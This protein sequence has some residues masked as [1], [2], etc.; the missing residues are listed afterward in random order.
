MPLTSNIG[1][2]IPNPVDKAAFDPGAVTLG[3][4][5]IT[6]TYTDAN[7]CTN[8]NTQEVLINPVTNVD[9]TI[10][11]AT[12]N[13][14]G[15]YELCSELGRVKLIG[16]PQANTGLPP[17]TMFTS[18]PAFPGGPLATILKDGSDFYIQTDGLVSN[19]Y[20]IRYD[21]KNVFGAV[22]FKMR[23][24]LILASPVA[25][26]TSSNNCIASDVLFTDATVINPTPFPTNLASWQWN[27]GDNSSSTMQNP[28]K[29]FSTSSTY[30]V[31]LKVTT[32]QGCSNTSAPLTHAIRVGDVP[33]P[34][35]QWAAIC[36]KDFTKFEDLSNPGN[37]SVITDYIW[38]FGD[39]N[40]L[41]GAAGASVPSG[42]HGGNTLGTYSLPDHKYNVFGT[43]DAKLTVTTNDGCSASI[44]KKVFILPY[45][46]VRPLENAAYYQTFEI[47]DGGWIAEAFDA[48]NSTRTN[49]IKSDTSWIWGIPTGQHITSGA[50]RS[51]KAWWT[52]RNKVGE[53]T[54]FANEN[55][56]VNGPCFDLTALK[57]PMISLDY[58]TD[59]DLSD[60]A[61]LQYSI[62]G[63]N[64]WRIVGPNEA[65]QDRDQGI[66]WFNGSS[67]PS[68]PGDQFLGQYGWTGNATNTTPRQGEWKNG[69]FNLDM[70]PM[71]NRSQVR[72]RVAFASNDGNPPQGP[73]DG[74]A[75]DN[76]FVGD[77]K[78]TVIVEHFTNSQLAASLKSAS[79]DLDDL[80]DDQFN[81]RVESDFFK[82]QYHM[83][84][85]GPDPLNT[86]NPTDPGARAFY[87]QNITQP[88]FTVM[89]GILGSYYNKVFIG[90][91][92][93]ITEI[94]ID[95]R[96]LED[97]AFVVDTIKIDPSA[98]SNIV[99]ATIE[100]VYVDSVTSL[101]SPV[102]F[103][104]ALIETDLNGN[105]NV[106]RKLLL[107][108]EGFTVNRAWQYM[109]KQTIDIN[110]TMDVQV[111]DP[112]KLYLVVFAQDFNT[113]RIHQAT[114]VKA[115]NKVG[116]PPVGIEDDPITA[117]IW[118]ISVFPN[119]AS[120]EVK[121]YLE[122]TLTHD[123]RWEI[124]DQRGVT[125]R[126]GE[127]NRDLSTPQEVAIHDL[128]N[129][130]YFVRF[131]L[132]DKTM[133]YRKLAIMN[134]H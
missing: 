123:F 54:Y 3:T 127:L 43:Y 50:R 36:N 84:V 68:N 99:R 9:F 27:F 79:Q 28:T 23:D 110:Y 122:N 5:Y 134:N 11:G 124:V 31:T 6:Y 12:L 94:E 120:K 49:I 82:I 90:S 119:P 65:L 39:G 117:E 74:F 25:E 62:D 1:S 98:P 104:A 2:T 55:S 24:V 7:N 15:Q 85:P 80:Y 47:T 34:D 64:N 102:T 51:T 133:V 93:N 59:A 111:S 10:Q 96:A 87:Y 97:P 19:T 92:K 77:K 76:V 108:S 46:T 105:K 114:M 44:T 91:H 107:Q 86:Q 128:A 101:R 89:D 126:D 70:I 100:F 13:A 66:N 22:T 20:R 130:I 38:D 21:F 71:A 30:Y 83:G 26:F 57:R 118:N 37:I 58:F 61:V 131:R 112:S 53:S 52:G 41:A 103:H 121:F 40:T 67:I 33:I 95:R 81:T 60:G 129:G 42:S 45:S 17:E 63:G 75:F 18:V 106:L 4:N 132:A 14:N 29:R 8:S 115:P 78:R 116:V 35:F 73:F 32:L 72:L 16:F 69:R 56:V 48:T 125:V 109:D 113:R 88:P